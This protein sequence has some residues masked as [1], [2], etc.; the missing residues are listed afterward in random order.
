MFEM[1]AGLYLGIGLIVAGFVFAMFPPV[2]GYKPS[3]SLIL[4]AAMT[5]ILLW[6]FLV[7]LGVGYLTGQIYCRLFE[8]EKRVTKRAPSS[9]R[10]LS[11]SYLYDE[12][13]IRN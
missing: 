1:Y 7:L 4:L 9:A 2:P 11:L 13:Q 5:Y 3:L 12:A 10:Q 6:P 8:R